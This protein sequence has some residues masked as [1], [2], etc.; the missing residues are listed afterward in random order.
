MTARDGEFGPADV[1]QIAITVQVVRFREPNSRE[2][3]GRAGIT[4]TWR[5]EQVCR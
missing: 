2:R 3:L 4:V 1:P 5:I